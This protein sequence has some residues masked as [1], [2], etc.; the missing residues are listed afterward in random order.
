MTRRWVRERY[1]E[2][3]NGSP[4]NSPLWQSRVLG[5]FPTSSSNALVP[6]S[7]LEHARRPAEDH[8]ERIVIG[9]DPAGPGR[10]LTACVAIAGGAIVEI[11]TFSD[12][13]A[14][15]P[16]VAFINRHRDRLR[17][18][19]VDSGGIGWYLA[20]HLRT[21]GI[22]TQGL[23]AAS[24]ATDKERYT[25]LKAERYFAL[26]Q[27]FQQGEISGLDDSTLGELAS[28]SYLV[29]PHGKIQIRRQSFRSIRAR[30]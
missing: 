15:G 4:E 16:V 9:V 8:A 13:D 7:A 17:L 14:R 24:S 30:S 26:R 19:Q 18:V 28:I 20:E 12:A 3:F 5:Q 1:A 21:L 22:G 27:R 23:N 11:A 6:L 25:N 29:D 2:W 10:D